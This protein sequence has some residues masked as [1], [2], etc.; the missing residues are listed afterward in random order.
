MF[1]YADDAP[2]CFFEFVVVP[3]ITC[4]VAVEFLVP[5]LPIPLRGGPVFRATVPEATI[6]EDSDALRREHDVGASPRNGPHLRVD[7]VAESSLV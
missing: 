6:Y 3:S 4:D 5:P 2:A 1:P 7:S